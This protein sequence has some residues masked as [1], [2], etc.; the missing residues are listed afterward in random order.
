MGS[1]GEL[2]AMSPEL[3]VAVSLFL[4]FFLAFSCSFLT[5]HSMARSA[6]RSFV[7]LPSFEYPFFNRLPGLSLLRFLSVILF[8]LRHILGLRGPSLH[9]R[10][11]LGRAVRDE[12]RGVGIGFIRFTLDGP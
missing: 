1:K 3:R 4:S 5:W 12:N 11:V 9:M 7:H 10:F 6:V 2:E 8:C